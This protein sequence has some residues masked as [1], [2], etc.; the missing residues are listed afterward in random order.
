MLQRF[1]CNNGFYFFPN[2]FF[3]NLKLELNV[4]FLLLI[5]LIKNFIIPFYSC[6]LI[7][8]K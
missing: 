3:S 6:H 2:L 1:C 8:N 5:F 7:I 4:H